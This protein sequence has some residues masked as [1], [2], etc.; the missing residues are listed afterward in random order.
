MTGNDNILIDSN[1]KTSCAHC[2]A[3]LGDAASNPIAL[4][5]HRRSPSSHAGPGVHADPGLFTDRA[6]ELRQSFCPSCLVLLTTEI[7][8]ADEPQYRGWT[9]SSWSPT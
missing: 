1:G 4:A 9:L 6:I 7:A 3:R 2:G 5:V 8:P